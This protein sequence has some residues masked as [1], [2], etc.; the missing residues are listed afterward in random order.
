[1]YGQLGY[2]LL[3]VVAED[4]FGVYGMRL[5]PHFS[6]ECIVQAFSV[7]LVQG[8]LTRRFTTPL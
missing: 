6:M 5:D 4:Q 7:G 2:I 1:M 3:T 8:Y